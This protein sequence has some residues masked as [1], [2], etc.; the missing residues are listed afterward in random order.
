[1]KADTIISWSDKLIV[2]S[3]QAMILYI[4]VSTAMVETFSSIIITA[5]FVKKTTAYFLNRKNKAPPQTAIPW[6]GSLL[7]FFKSYKPE[8]NYINWPMG[9]YLC[10]NLLSVI[11]SQDHWL[12]LKGFIFKLFQNIALFYAFWECMKTKKQIQLFVFL[13]LLI[14]FLVAINGFI[15]YWRVYDFVYF[16]ALLNDRVLS[17]FKHPNDFA[18][19]LLIP[20]L[21]SLGLLT[22]GTAQSDKIRNPANSPKDTAFFSVPDQI[23]LWILLGLFLLCFGLTFS[24]GAWGSFMLALVW[25]GIMERKTIKI[26]ILVVAIFLA[27]FVPKMV[28]TRN[29]SFLSDE[30]NNHAQSQGEVKKDSSVTFLQDTLKISKNFAGQGRKVFWKEAINVIRAFPVLGAGLN[31]YSKVAPEFSANWE[32]YYAH[33]C[34]LQMTAETGI[35][36][37]LAFIWIIWRLLWQAI[38]NVRQIEDKFLSAAFLGFFAGWT[39]FMMHSFVDTNF[40]SVQLGTLMWVVMG[41]MVAIEKLAAKNT[42]EKA[43]SLR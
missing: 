36:G 23:R 6:M 34:Y 3:F 13:N 40:Y 2:F 20:L 19:Y 30:V 17:T 4:P 1:M 21:L 11:F 8:P 37:L 5:L 41:A 29:V 43:R 27:M 33:N 10:A 24:R 25:L 9:I 22:G 14:T 35:I 38:K 26:S 32:G 16:H 15:Q 18:A 31:T 42:E 28:T 39:A 7:N 12:S